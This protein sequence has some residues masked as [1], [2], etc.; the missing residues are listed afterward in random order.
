MIRYQFSDETE[1]LRHRRHAMLY[2]TEAILHSSSRRGTYSTKV[3]CYLAYAHLLWA[4]FGQRGNFKY[5][6]RVPARPSGP[7]A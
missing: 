1:D 3:F 6:V 7:V 4:V 2:F 5:S